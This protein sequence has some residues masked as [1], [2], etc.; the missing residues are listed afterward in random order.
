M[1]LVPK[2]PKTRREIS[3]CNVSGIIIVY[4]KYVATEIS[5]IMSCFCV[6]IYSP[7]I[8]VIVRSVLKVNRLELSV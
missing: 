8:L 2:E 3:D 4:K 1:Y 6:I 5:K 7:C